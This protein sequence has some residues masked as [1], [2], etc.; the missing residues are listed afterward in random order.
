MPYG[1][2]PHSNR[3]MI[4]IL[5]SLIPGFGQIYLRQIFKGFALILSVAL[6]IIIIWF[7]VSHKEFKLLDLHGKQVMFNPTIKYVSFW[8]QTVR[9]TEIMK[10]SGTVQLV[11][12]WLFSIFDAWKESRKLSTIDVK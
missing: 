6:A 9:V 2:P 10:I 7:A 3:A 1:V 12:T 11:F 5:L 4:A 8:G